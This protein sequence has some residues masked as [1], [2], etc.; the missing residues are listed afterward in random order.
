[1]NRPAT[2]AEALAELERAHHPVGGHEAV[3]VGDGQ[4]GVVERAA[5]DLDLQLGVRPTEG[6]RG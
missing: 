2:H 1:M 3:D 5:D 6:P 4:A